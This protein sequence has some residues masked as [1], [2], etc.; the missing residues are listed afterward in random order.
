MFGTDLTDGQG[1]ILNEPL[2]NS[3]D[4]YSREATTREATLKETSFRK[5]TT[6]T[7]SDIFKMEKKNEKAQNECYEMQRPNADGS[8][9]LILLVDRMDLHFN[10][11][12]CQVLKFTDMTLLQKLKEEKE[13]THLLKTLTACVSHDMITPLNCIIDFA[14]TIFEETTSE[15]LK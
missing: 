14:S 8:D 7:L 10:D 11:Q 12:E 15:S 1:D 6:F 5:S 4:I 9:H 13:T 3:S 2:F